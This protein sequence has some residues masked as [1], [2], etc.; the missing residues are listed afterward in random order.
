[1]TIRWRY[2]LYLALFTAAQVTVGTATSAVPETR[3]ELD[4]EWIQIPTASGEM[5]WIPRRAVEMQARFRP[6]FAEEDVEFV[7][8]SRSLSSDGQ[9]FRL[10][11]LE[12]LDEEVF[13]SSRPTRVVIHGWLNNRNSPM[14]VNIRD[15]Y[16]IGWDLN[17]IVVD[18]SK[19][20]NW[21]NYIS[22]TSCVRVVGN[23]LSKLLDNLQNS[24]GLSLNDV[25]LIGHSLGAHAAGIAGK[26]CRDISTI[27]ALDPAL[28]L[29]SIHNP[30][31][32]VD[33]EDAE[34]VEV[35]HT[36]GGL[37]GFLEPVGT[38]DYYPNGGQKQPGCGLNLAGI[39][40]HSRAWQLFVETLMEPEENLLAEPIYTIPRLPVEE[41]SD[42]GRRSK[43]GGEPSSQA[44]GLFYIDTN[45]RS[46][47]F[48]TNQKSN[49][50]N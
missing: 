47:Y 36:S 13:L 38:A 31:N 10:S 24:R 35:I 49:E 32:R 45:D 48:G 41:K 6:A 18:W 33:V 37:L 3:R 44:N 2:G 50:T 42:S 25:Y 9:T 21:L 1:M 46:P 26:S 14:S 22:V 4:S 27:I 40:A 30:E 19:C 43:M 20:A 7:F 8:Y 28:P 29:F 11:S 15:A 16:L 23:A 12:E 17:V 5:I 39:C 34:Y